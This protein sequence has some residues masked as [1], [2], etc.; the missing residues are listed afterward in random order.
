MN[1][2]LNNGCAI[3]SNQCSINALILFFS[4]FR[5]ALLIVIIIVPGTIIMTQPSLAQDSF[6]DA[7][8]QY[9]ASTGFDVSSGFYGADERT[10]VVYMPATLQAAKG[11]W[12]AR[13]VFSYLYV[14]GPALLIDGSSAGDSL[15]VR[16]SGEADGPGD[17]NLYGTYS[18]ESLYD[19][20]LFLD[21]TARVKAPTASFNKGLGTEAWDFAVQV[22]VAQAF[23]NFVP[24]ATLGY[25]F[26][27]NP[28]GFNLRDVVYGS[29]GLQYSVSD[30]FTTGAYYDIRQP[31]I[32]GAATPQEGTA[33]VNVRMSDDWSL[34]L[35]GVKGFSDNSPSVGGGLSITYRWR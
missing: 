15:G 18:F 11:P 30:T 34:L 24:F 35:Y 33:Y 27:G 26:T 20:G 12:T 9:R 28:T 8:W 2:V 1:R 25:R 23:D 22:D 13:A 21:L 19:Q 5:A 3:A 31:S 17:I 6:A 10:T 7:F 29:A 32:R 4:R 14:S 16:T